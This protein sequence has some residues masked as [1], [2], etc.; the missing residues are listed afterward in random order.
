MWPLSSSGPP[1]RAFHKTFGVDNPLLAA[2]SCV[3]GCSQGLSTEQR[4]NRCRA[5]NS[6]Y[7]LTQ[8]SEEDQGLA[9]QGAL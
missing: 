4:V 5:K 6:D 8:V 9:V 1:L 7:V 2:L 3:Q